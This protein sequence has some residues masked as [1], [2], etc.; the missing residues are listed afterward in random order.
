MKK[1]KTVAYSMLREFS[2]KYELSNYSSVTLDKKLITALNQ[3]NKQYE[4]KAFVNKITE[5]MKG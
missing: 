3:S 2:K 1:E 4:I 5:K